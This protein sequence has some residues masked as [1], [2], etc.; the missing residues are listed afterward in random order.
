ME[1]E[2]CY[3]PEQADVLSMWEAAWDLR[4]NSSLTELPRLTGTSTV[5][6]QLYETH[7]RTCVTFVN[8]AIEAGLRLVCGPG[9]TSAAAPAQAETSDTVQNDPSYRGYSADL[10]NVSV[11]PATKCVLHGQRMMDT[12][13]DAT[14]RAKKSWEAILEAGCCP[15]S[16]DKFK[17]SVLPWIR[18]IVNCPQCRDAN[19]TLQAST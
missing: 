19:I 10:N 17:K 13:C 12:L 5:P 2:A 4:V 16:K 9:S 15:Y 14:S 11:H 8:N 18:G 6:V 3:W 7:L 1:I